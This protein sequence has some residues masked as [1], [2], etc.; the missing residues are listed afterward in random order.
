[1]LRRGR[2]L[3]EVSESVRQ[4]LQILPIPLGNFRLVLLVKGTFFELVL[5]ERFIPGL[6]V[7]HGENFQLVRIPVLLPNVL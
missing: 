7:A 1:M 2:L 4:T 5:L 6:V 3:F